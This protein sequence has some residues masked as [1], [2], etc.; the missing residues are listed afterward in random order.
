[1]RSLDGD[2]SFPPPPASFLK[3]HLLLP[4]PLGQP[5]KMGKKSRVVGGVIFKPWQPLALPRGRGDHCR[6][7][8]QERTQNSRCTEQS[9]PPGP[10]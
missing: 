6:G 3:E 9:H 1:M 7:L 4:A 10:N 5:W 8:K 2:Q